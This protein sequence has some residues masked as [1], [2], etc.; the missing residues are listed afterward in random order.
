MYCGT[1]L[2]QILGDLTYED[3][4]EIGVSDVGS[5]R[6]VFREITTWRDERDYKKAEAIRARM[7][8]QEQ[9]H[10]AQSVQEDVGHRLGMLKS[11]L[12]SLVSQ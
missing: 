2:L 8:A 10:Y 12:S 7:A 9:K 5:R 4:K 11:S 6:K 3:I 1:P